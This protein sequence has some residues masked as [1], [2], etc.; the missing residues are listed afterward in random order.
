MQHGMSVSMEPAGRRASMRA[1]PTTWATS[2]C[3]SWTSSAT[4]S[5]TRPRRSACA[6]WAPASSAW[7]VM[8]RFA[9][10]NT[11]EFASQAPVCACTCMR[12]ESLCWKTPGHTP[13]S[14]GLLAGRHCGQGEAV[15]AEGE[16]IPADRRGSSAAGHRH[17]LGGFQHQPGS[18]T[19]QRDSLHVL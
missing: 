1:L 5:C 17:R 19:H 8:G 13:C 10:G 15:S 18:L 11:Q 14:P 12:Y 9:L 6:R 2:C 3:P 7:L 4:P 16:T